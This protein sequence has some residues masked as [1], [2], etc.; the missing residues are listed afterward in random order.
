MAL[1]E[2]CCRFRFRCY[3]RIAILA[4]S[5]IQKLQPRIDEICGKLWFF[6]QGEELED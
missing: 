4:R 3:F 2:H 1:V 5:E 6:E